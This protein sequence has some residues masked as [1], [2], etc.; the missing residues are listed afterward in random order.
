MTITPREGMNKSKIDFFILEIDLA[1]SRFSRS[2]SQ[3]SNDQ[4]ST[5]VR[6]KG[7]SA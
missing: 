7:A 3:V 6:Q 1:S 2:L 5:D 4:T